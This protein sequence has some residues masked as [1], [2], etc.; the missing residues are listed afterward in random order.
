MYDKNKEEKIIETFRKAIPSLS[1]LEKEKLLSF[2]E[3]I[4]FKA[5]KQREVA[6]EIQTCWQNS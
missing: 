3:G 6:Q 5:A 1:A 2:A 4:A